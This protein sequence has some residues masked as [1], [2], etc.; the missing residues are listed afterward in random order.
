MFKKY[1]FIACF[2]IYN[3]SFSQNDVITKEETFILSGTIFDDVLLQPIGKAN[4][5][6]SGG[7]YTTSSNAGDFRIR[8]RIGDEIIIRSDEFETVYFTIEDEQSYAYW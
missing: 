4:I 6:I 8:A 5:E 3:A 1:F 7:A 2:F